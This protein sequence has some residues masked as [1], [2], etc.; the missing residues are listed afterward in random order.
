MV[1]ISIPQFIKITKI[2]MITK[3]K[4]KGNK[5]QICWPGGYRS[6]I[7]ERTIYF[8]FLCI[9]LRVLRLEVPYPV[10]TLQTSF[11]PL[12]LGGGGGG[13]VGSKIR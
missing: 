1:D 7:L 10:F 9:I 4:K 8:R 2:S 6:R 3:K 5:I 12:L 11:K 13:G